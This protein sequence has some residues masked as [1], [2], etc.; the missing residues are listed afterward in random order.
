MILLYLLGKNGRM[1][2]TVCRIIETEKL[3]IR[4]LTKE[5]REK[6]EI[7]LDFS[8]PDAV[9]N[10]ID[11]FQSQNFHPGW[12]IGSTGWT[13]D[14]SKVLKKLSETSPVLVAPN[15]SIGIALMQSALK[16]LLV[17]I[18]KWSHK[19][20]IQAHLEETHHIH[21]KDRP[22]GTALALLKTLEPLKSQPQ[23]TVTETSHRVGEVVGDH[24]VLFKSSTEELQ[25]SHRA[26]D[27]SVFAQGAL[28]AAFWM[29]EQRMKNPNITG[30]FTFENTLLM[31]SGSV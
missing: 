11:F 14:Q 20:P 2:S 22:S 30:Q 18:Q 7:V 19:T 4:V 12:I 26:L 10:E 15:F 9:L 17:P 13:E 28:H 3:P 23:I 5:N 8:S 16:H 1:G 29:A 31:A 6:A 21:K 24:S 27:R 25:I